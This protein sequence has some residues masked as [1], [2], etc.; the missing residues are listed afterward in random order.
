MPSLLDPKNQHKKTEGHQATV[1]MTPH[2]RLFP[3]RNSF[4]KMRRSRRG[5]TKSVAAPN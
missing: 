4:L 5:N 3:T 2:A 1:S